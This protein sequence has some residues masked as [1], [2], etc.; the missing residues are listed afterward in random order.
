[1][2]AELRYYCFLSAANLNNEGVGSLTNGDFA[3]A[4]SCFKQALKCCSSFVQAGR[5][6]DSQDSID[7]SLPSRDDRYPTR[8][9]VDASV[10][11]AT[12]ETHP[13]SGF[14]SP[15][16]S[17][18]HSPSLFYRDIPYKVSTADL[19]HSD[20]IFVPFRLAQHRL[21][22]EETNP[23]K[24]ASTIADEATLIIYTSC[25]TLFNLG[26][27]H[28]LFSMLSQQD[29]QRQERSLFKALAFYK[30]SRSL[31]YVCMNRESDEISSSLSAN[32]GPYAWRA[33][34][35]LLSMATFN[36]MAHISY[37]IA[38]YSDLQVN[39]QELI[40]AAAFHESAYEQDTEVSDAMKKYKAR[41]L[42]NAF[43]MQTPFHA[44]TA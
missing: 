28:H 31:L 33:T 37:E 5:H 7:G 29:K 32:I 34:C 15:A 30:K 12:A 4:N 36:N 42:F 26:L 38:A 2:T 20:G 8:L 14:L 39:I 11:L 22:E 17:P 25:I 41:F 18:C 10:Q 24:K 6:V 19:V 44:A 27:L 43:L 1:M 9:P 23:K 21:L 40:R 35:D 16:L 13:Y 3:Q